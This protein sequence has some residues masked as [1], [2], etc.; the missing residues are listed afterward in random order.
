MFM[1]TPEMP[2]APGGRSEQSDSDSCLVD[3]IEK[4]LEYDADWAKEI[5]ERKLGA[6]NPSSTT[7]YIQCGR[8]AT[9]FALNKETGS[10]TI[11]PPGCKLGDTLE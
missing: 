1:R 4:F 11:S 8:C 2:P 6:T 7:S 3:V 10:V 5:I 9:A